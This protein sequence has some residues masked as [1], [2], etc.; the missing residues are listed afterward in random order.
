MSEDNQMI[1]HQLAHRSIRQFNQAPLSDETIAQLEQVARRTA[2]SHYLQA[3]SL[4][5]IHD[6]TKRAAIAEIC[7]Q[8]YVNQNGAL[9]LFVADQHRAA[10]IARE[11]GVS[12]AKLGRADKFFQAVSDTVLAAQNM[13]NAAEA[14]GLGTVFL[15]SI[16]N[17]AQRLIELLQLPPLTF[18]VLGLL[19]GQPAERPQTK[20]RLPKEAVV[21]T[22]QYGLKPPVTPTLAAYDRAVS[23]YYETRDTNRRPETF[24]GLVART[25][26][27]VQAKR[28]DLFKILQHQGFFPEADGA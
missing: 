22:D 18:P 12:A 2:T 16:Q 24:T 9:W 15:G 20:P 14:L 25:A 26:D 1:Q 7:Q 28:G 21:F 3:F 10:L 5:A 19:V 11:A 27:Q 6:R 23:K 17:D 13:A 8:D 4:I